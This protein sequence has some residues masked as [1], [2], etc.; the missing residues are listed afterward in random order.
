MNG[1]SLQSTR[2]KF[3]ARLWLDHPPRRSLGFHLL[4]ISAFLGLPICGLLYLFGRSRYRAKLY[5][6]N[7][8]RSNGSSS[9]SSTIPTAQPPITTKSSSSRPTMNSLLPLVPPSPVQPNHKVDIPSESIGSS[10]FTTSES[11]S[12]KESQL[13][14]K[15]SLPQA[16][17]VELQSMVPPRK[18]T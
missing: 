14:G 13:S 4:E 15:L 16:E 3:P 1:S 10:K 8:A 9:Y 11:S 18:K 12:L 17:V 2:R 7:I 6:Q 5:Y